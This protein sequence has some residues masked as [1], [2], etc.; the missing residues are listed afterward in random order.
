MEA[1]TATK[2]KIVNEKPLIFSYPR[3]PI[4]NRRKNKINNDADF[5]IK[6]KKTA[7]N[8]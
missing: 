1:V 8:Q 3:T 6:L 7:L 2:I 4:A 5:E